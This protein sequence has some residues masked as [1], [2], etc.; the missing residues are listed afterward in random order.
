[1]KWCEIFTTGTH[2]DSKGNERTW[3]KSDLEK[4]KYNFENKNPDFPI[5][6]GHPQ[7]NSPAYGWVDELKIEDDAQKVSHLYASYKDVQ[8]EFKEAYNKGLFKTRSLSLTQDLIPRHIAFLGAQAPAIKGLE[9]FCFEACDNEIIIEFEAENSP[10]MINQPNPSAGADE[11]SGSNKDNANEYK[12]NAKLPAVVGKENPAPPLEPEL[13]TNK[14][15]QDMPEN[16]ELKQQLAQKDD[17]IAALKKQV[18]DSKQAALTKEF[19]DFCD[20]AISE[21]HLLPAQREAVLNIL[22]ATTDNNINFADRETKSATEVFKDFI[23][24]LNQMDFQDIATFKNTDKDKGINFQD[25]E[26]VKK[27]ILEIQNEYA[28][29]GIKLSV[30]EAYETLK[31]K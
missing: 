31:V 1:M 3:T 17:E 9:K 2:K 21:G 7:S 19:Q 5:C 29:K 16:E 13:N 10:Y 18:E 30:T 20:N 25:A 26:E 23:S 6:C 27:G 12:L 24:G 11:I 15:G 8:P 4:I 14:K 28:Q 22:F